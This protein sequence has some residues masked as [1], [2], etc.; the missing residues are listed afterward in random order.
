MFP[1]SVKEA[2]ETIVFIINYKGE[3]VETTLYDHVIKSADETTSPRGVMT[4]IFVEEIEADHY[5]VKSWGVGGRGPAKTIDT[6]NTEEEARDN[7]YSRIYNFDF[8]ADDQRDTNYYLT[9]AE[10]E[11]HLAELY[12]TP[13]TE[14][15]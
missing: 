8:M 15:E 4:R 13:E 14:Q 5:A 12:P 11:Q 3:I 7:W 2:K 9:R 10:A 1:Q 6:F